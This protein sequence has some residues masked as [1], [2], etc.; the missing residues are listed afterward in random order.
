VV[1]ADGAPVAGATV[2]AEHRPAPTAAV[3]ET[4]RTAR[5]ITDDGGGFAFSA[6]APGDYDVAAA[7]DVRV[8]AR[9]RAPAG[10]RDVVLRLGAA[11]RLRGTVRGEGG[12]PVVAF[13]VILTPRR[14]P[15]EGGGPVTRTFFDARGAF[16]VDGLAPGAY[17]VRVVAHGFAP[18]PARD[19]PIA[20][21]ET[22]ADFT[23]GA[24][25]RITGV[26]LEAGTRT[27]LAGANVAIEGAWIDELPLAARVVTDATGA[28]SL[29]GV[30][31]GRCSLRVAASGHHGR[32]LGGLTVA[33]PAS[34]GPVTVELTRVDPGEEPR[35]ELVGIGAVLAARDDALV[36]GELTPAGGGAAAGLVPGDAV[37]KV[38]GQPVVDLGFQEAIQLIRGPEGTTVVLT[39]RR[40]G[41]AVVEVPVLRKPIRW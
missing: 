11:A 10:A 12:A 34:L 22:A 39:V 24:G 25:A 23:L 8:S 6:L 20:A 19:V 26:V 1:G 16:A 5:A 3:V 9:V 30:P 32:I 29:G 4:P 18:A 27:P 14:G 17:A 7:A 40:A 41:G 37:L 15:L 28:F 21:P 35:L 36:I 13:A 31:A 2:L 38:E 33:P